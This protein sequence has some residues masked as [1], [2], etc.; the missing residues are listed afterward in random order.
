MHAKLISLPLFLPGQNDACKEFKS[1]NL[2]MS[3]GAENILKQTVVRQWYWFICKVG[4]VILTYYSYLLKKDI[5]ILQKYQ[6]TS[7]NNINSNIFSNLGLSLY[8]N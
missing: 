5:L 8:R 3:P 6:Q 2:K 4:M 1:I 7:N